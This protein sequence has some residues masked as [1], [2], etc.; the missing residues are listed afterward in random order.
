MAINTSEYSESTLIEQPA[1]ALFTE[2]GWQSA[3]CFHETYG[4][5]S[6]HGRETPSEVVL[7]KGLRSAIVQ[8]IAK[9]VNLRR[10]RDLLLPKLISGE[11]NVEDI[12]VRMPSKKM[13]SLE[14]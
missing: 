3:N 2:L 8:M 14:L 12:K 4:P 13:I 7:V 6:T 11:V 5:N 10:T 9:N 1:I